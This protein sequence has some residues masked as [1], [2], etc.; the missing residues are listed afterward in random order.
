MPSNHRGG[1]SP[2]ELPP[3]LARLAR[4]EAG[5]GRGSAEGAPFGPDALDRGRAPRR[6]PSVVFAAIVPGLGMWR[7]R[8]FLG[9]FLFGLGV[10]VPLVVVAFVYVDDGSTLRFALDREVLRIAIAV[11]AVAVA[12]R[13]ISVFEALFAGRG[14]PRNG[15]AT[16]LAFGVVA[17]LGAGVALSAVR[18][19][20]FGEALELVFLDADGDAPVFGNPDREFST[21]LLLG[22]DEGKGRFGLRTDTM[23]LVMIHTESGR[24][25]LVSVPRNLTKLRFPAGSAMATRFPN[26]FDDLANA[27]YPY[28]TNREDLSGAYARGAVPPGAI[29]ITEGIGTSLDI[30]ID[31][32]AIVNML[33]FADLVDAVGGVTLEL[34]SSVALPPSP[35]GAKRPV[36]P[37]IGPGFVGLDGTMAL[38]YARTRYA[39]SDYERMGRQRELLVALFTQVGVRT[40]FGRLD[41]ISTAVEGAL[42]TSLTPKEL[43][44]LVG[45]LG[46]GGAI[47]ESVG[48]VP[49]LFRPG[50]PDF[51]T[52]AL[53][54][55]GLR[56][57][58]RSGEPFPFRA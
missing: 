46:D 50:R 33:G 21:V 47:V 15:F 26:G 31:D 49:P 43:T 55:E 32:I 18:F 23:I 14:L 28:V 53:I 57:A 6:S 24:T 29:A 16:A 4:L 1:E 40:A 56:E 9:P 45:V 37:S 12:A 39:D 51:D 42:R 34:P 36:P 22:G 54:V 48:L 7:R 38:A 41:E 5:T 19:E 3:A 27:V 58:L 2:D 30:A 20:R 35:P 44:S 25:A 10:I 13:F 17:T 8:P 52:A 11:G